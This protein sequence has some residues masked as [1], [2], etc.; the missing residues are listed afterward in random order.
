MFNRHDAVVGNVVVVEVEPQALGLGD[1]IV[2]GIELV[3][4][5]A[6]A[7]LEDHVLVLVLVANGVEDNHAAVLIPYG[8]VIALR[9]VFNCGFFE[10]RV[11][12][13]DVCAREFLDI[14]EVPGIR[15]ALFLMEGQCEV[16]VGEVGHV[17]VVVFH[18]LDADADHA[19]LTLVGVAHRPA[20]RTEEV[21]V[22][23]T[24][25]VS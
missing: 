3:A 10:F 8:E 25:R 13:S 5:D 12:S 17:V 11:L 20:V 16:A 9:L 19:N 15:I 7:V 14:G 21:Q 23:D 24:G 1:H 6:L 4:V 22:G 18:I 2:V